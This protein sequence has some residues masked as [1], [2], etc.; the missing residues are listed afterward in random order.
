M[1]IT[2]HTYIQQQ[3]NAKWTSN[4]IIHEALSTPL[5]ILVNIAPPLT[6]HI[7]ITIILSNILFTLTTWIYT[8]IGVTIIRARTCNSKNCLVYML[9]DTWNFKNKKYENMKTITKTSNWNRLDSKGGQKNY[10]FSNKMLQCFACHNW[11]FEIS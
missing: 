3:Q 6:N 2:K 5:V 9:F 7:P 11:I 10:V 4:Q 8:L 1:H